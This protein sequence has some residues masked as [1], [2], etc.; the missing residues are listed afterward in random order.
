VVLDPHHGLELRRFRQR[1]VVDE[2]APLIDA[3]RRSEVLLKGSVIHGRPAQDYGSPSTHQ[4]V[5]LPP[6]GTTPDRGGTGDQP[7]RSGGF[8]VVPGA[9]AQ[10]DW[11][12]T[13][14]PPPT[15]ASRRSAPSPRRC[16]THATRS[17]FFTTSQGAGHWLLTLCPVQSVLDQAVPGIGADLPQVQQTLRLLL[18]PDAGALGTLS[19]R[20]YA[21]AR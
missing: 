5:K 3:M 18:G 7:G 10:V 17:A 12:T 15:S 21:R 2:V 6:G 14:S 1:R 20:R 19:L 8:E 9:Q 13:A 4:R 16:R 11:A